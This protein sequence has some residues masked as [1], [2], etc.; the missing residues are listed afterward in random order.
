MKPFA[1][2]LLSLVTGAAIGG[3][4][5]PVHAEIEFARDIQ[6]ILSDKCYTCHGPDAS[7][8]K[9]GLRLDLREAAFQALDDSGTT[10]AIVAH[11]PDQSL[12]IERIETDDPDDR[13][14]PPESN[15]TLSESERSLLRQWIKAGAPWEEHWAFVPP[16]RPG[17]P[18][19]TE[20]EWVRNPID[21][22]VAE[23]RSKQGA[24]K[25][26]KVANPERL[27][28][29]LTIDL[30][31]LPPTLEE[32]DTFLA[33]SR[34]DRY[35]RAVDRLLS[36]EGYAERMALE[37]MDVSR[38]ADSHGMHADGWRMMW[39][40]RDWVLDAFKRNQPYDQFITWQ[41]A[42]DLLPDPTDEQIIAT[43]F[44]RNHAM[45]AEG[46]I[47]D[48]EFR[49]QYVFDRA[50]T[51]A[52]AFLGLTLECARCHDHKF[53]PLSQK[54][55]Y[56]MTAFFNN[57][58][59]LGMTGDDGNY[60]PMHLLSTPEQKARLKALD[61][62]IQTHTEAMTALRANVAATAETKSIPLPNPTAHFRF[63]SIQMV[64]E[65]KKKRRLDGNESA[66]LS[67]DPQLVAGRLGKAIAFDS[68]YDIVTLA[69]AGLID[70][71]D[72]FTASVWIQPEVGGKPQTI[73]G[74][75]GAKNNFWRGWEFFLDSE[76]R[77]AVRLI[78]SLPHA[79]V[80]VRSQAP[81]PLKT[82]SQVAFTYDG[83]GQAAG[84]ALFQNGKPLVTET[85]Y[86]RL[87][88]TIYPVSGNAQRDRE[89]RAL[90][91]GKSY[92]SFTG[93]YGIYQ[94]LIDDL[95]LYDQALTAAE[96]WTLFQADA[97]EEGEPS[98]PSNEALTQHQ[99]IRHNAQYAAHQK[100]LRHLFQERLALVDP[101]PELMIMEELPEPRPTYVLRRGQYDAPEERVQAATPEAVLPFDESLPA[102]RLGLARWL[103][104]P[105]NP[106]T[107]RVTVNRY[108]QLFFGV[109]LVETTEDF[110][111]Q[112]TRPSHPELLDWLAVEFRDSGWDLRHLHKLILTSATYR[113]SSEVPLEA[114]Q[115]D[116]KNRLLSRGP[117]HRLSAE[118]I[119]DQALAASGLLVP[120]VG[121]ASVKPFQPE[122]LW[123]D[124]GNFSAKLLRYQPDTGEALYRR[125][126]YTFIRRTSPHP[127]MVA[128]DA[129]NRD[130]CQVRRERTNT[131]LQALVLMNDPQF[132]EAARIFAERIQAEG[133][134]HLE[135]Q[136]RFA[137]R[138]VTSRFPTATE[139]EILSEL[140]R[141]E[142]ERMKADPESA[143]ALLATGS[144][145]PNAALPKPTTGAL[146][147]LA[148]TLLNH[149]EF[150]TKR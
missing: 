21:H 94:G 72:H 128:F 112:G 139:T 67:G 64:G 12:L 69:K 114:R 126:L 2:T 41:L 74:N 86:S 45:T 68:E 115:Q 76:N 79:Y 9:A 48:E 132:V 46:G 113:Q 30:T 101:I 105:D 138:T 35:E 47:V 78:H 20:P 93:E 28:R 130:V 106:L 98:E 17:L 22:F 58:K 95:R 116:P 129:P 13:M 99:L 147:I 146:T 84:V 11:Q 59:E 29:R 26:A 52:T 19:T 39:P 18:P 107:A 70:T 60:G 83:S 73:V 100:A 49:M 42:G 37:W 104:S 96:V 40:W 81:V 135:D 80:H 120:R 134:E 118:L 23:T 123:I 119:R 90:R 121:G 25:P 61:R 34:P 150:Y 7:Q 6:R 102:N 8:R 133:G 149:D 38:Y 117:S 3:A 142:L 57:V 124:K 136:I 111:K 110:G 103:F 127:A 66:S 109:G 4:A 85:I 131:P 27:L 137:F 144:Q 62:E 14:P 33:D 53:D 36:S 1:R 148:N 108:W 43:A 88:K 10:F 92:R 75:S 54:D 5:L 15:L 97:T 63:D 31:G 87:D 82:W 50:Q 91:L 24:L 140:V 89:D 143:T 51:T 77:I 145:T 71:T 16:T 44:H 56:R 125:S 65:E 122:G 32:L 141:G 55:Y